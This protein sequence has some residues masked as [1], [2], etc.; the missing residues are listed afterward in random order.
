MKDRGNRSAVRARITACRCGGG[1]V[2][3]ADPPLASTKRVLL[4]VLLKRTQDASA[5]AIGQVFGW[6]P[7]TVRDATTDCTVLAAR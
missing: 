1:G 4:I 2:P 3:S 7:H 6:L 5:T